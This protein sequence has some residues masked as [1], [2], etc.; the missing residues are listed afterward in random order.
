MKSFIA[1]TPNAQLPTPTRPT[2]FGVGG[3]KLEVDRVSALREAN[4]DASVDKP[5]RRAGRR[6][7][8]HVVLLVEEI[9]RRDEQVDVAADGAHHR[10]VE[11]AVTRQSDHPA[12]PDA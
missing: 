7:Q 6:Q 10:E 12:R 3:W 5:R 11:D 8:L 2:M 9:L 4:A 1:S